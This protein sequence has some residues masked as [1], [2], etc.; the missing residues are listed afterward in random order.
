MSATRNK[1]TLGNYN[2][3]QQEYKSSRNYIDYKYSYAGRAYNPAL[4]C[5]GMNP[6]H[7][8]RDTFSTNSIDV[9]TMLFG[10]N[11]TNLVHPD[12]AP[13]EP[14]LKTL[15][16]IS[17]FNRLQLIMPNPLVVENKQRPLFN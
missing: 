5:I 11:S 8:P 9:E 1:N 3:E 17:Y 14:A 4:A 6:S 12:K 13:I 7:M 10:I 2:L 16:T 15:P